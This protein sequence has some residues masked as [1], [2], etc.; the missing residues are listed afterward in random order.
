MEH[1]NNPLSI[2]DV[3]A[4]I[5]KIQSGVDHRNIE[6]FTQDGFKNQKVKHAFL[7]YKLMPNDDIYSWLNN[8][9]CTSESFMITIYKAHIWHS[10]LIEKLKPFIMSKFNHDKIKNIKFDISMFL[11]HYEFTPFGIH[12][13]DVDFV[14]H[15]NVGSNDKVIYYWDTAPL[16]SNKYE[17]QNIL[18]AADMSI[19]KAG[20]LYELNPKRFHIGSSKNGVSFD[21]I[22]TATIKN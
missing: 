13:D 22:L 17:P 11:G 16:F 18:N 14:Y 6:V 9:A 20:E 3:K 19:I 5:Y 12:V 21:F 1:S 7:G 4:L 2:E 8:V 15:F 10:E